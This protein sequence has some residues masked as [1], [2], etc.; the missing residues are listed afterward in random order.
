MVCVISLVSCELKEEKEVL[1]E[2]PIKYEVKPELSVYPPNVV[3]PYIT[4]NMYSRLLLKSENENKPI[5]I[6]KISVHGLQ[7][8]TTKYNKIDDYNYFIYVSGTYEELTSSPVLIIE[9]VN[10]TAVKVPFIK[11][12]STAK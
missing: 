8:L 9:L 10:D 3:L 5:S 2:F 4:N 12:I 11:K 6:D 1:A 7:G